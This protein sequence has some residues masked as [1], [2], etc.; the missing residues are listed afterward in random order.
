[1]A[2]FSSTMPDVLK[3][4]H[5]ATELA[6]ELRVKPVTLYRCVGPNGE[7]RTNGKRVLRS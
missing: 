2:M 7:L 6:A 4:L 3:P 5:V 1:M